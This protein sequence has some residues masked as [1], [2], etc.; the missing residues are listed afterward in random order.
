MSTLG[1]GSSTSSTRPRINTILSL[2]PSHDDDDDDDDDI[3]DDDDDDDIL[4]FSS[5]M[6]R[7][8]LIISELSTP[9]CTMCE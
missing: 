3:D 8:F 2:S 6:S 4:P 9:V 5:T 1:T 7:A